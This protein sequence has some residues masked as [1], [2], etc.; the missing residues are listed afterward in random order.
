MDIEQFKTIFVSSLKG[1][2]ELDALLEL[3]DND[4]VFS[5]PFHTIRGKVM[6]ETLYRNAFKHLINPRFLNVKP[7]MKNKVLFVSWELNFKRKGMDHDYLIPGVSWIELNKADLISVHKDY[8]DSLALFSNPSLIGLIV[9]FFKNHV[10][11]L[12]LK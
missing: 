10:A 5:D 8:W 12:Q 2:K 1:P 6:L 11:K 7:Y 4:C 9:S 3:Y